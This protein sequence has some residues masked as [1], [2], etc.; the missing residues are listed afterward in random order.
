MFAVFPGQPELWLITIA[1]G[2]FTG[3]GEGAERAVISDF[4][5]ADER[6]TA[7][8]WYNLVLGL[9]AIPA[10]LLFGGVWHYLGAPAAFLMAAALAVVAVVLLR[11]WAWPTRAPHAAAAK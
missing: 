1:Y 4:A 2:L 9:A 10:G 3:F 7:F 5:A 11:T 6:G 8:G